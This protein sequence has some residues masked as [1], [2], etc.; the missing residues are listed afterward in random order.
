MKLKTIHFIFLLAFL[1]S[2]DASTKPYLQYELQYKKLADDCSRATGKFNMNS[3]TNG[4]RYVFEECLGA[5]FSKDQIIVE[6]HGDTVVIGFKEQQPSRLYELT[7]DI[8]TYPR[9]H[10]LTIGKTTFSIIPA[11]N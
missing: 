5:G 10:F 2:C 11:A 7:V 3:N 4:E 6:R 9:Y 8:D 1:Y